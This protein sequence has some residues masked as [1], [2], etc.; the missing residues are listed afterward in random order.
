MVPRVA[1]DGQR[2][3]DPTVPRVG[4]VAGAWR[5]GLDVSGQV[6]EDTVWAADTVRVVGPLEVVNG[7]TLGIDAGVR[8]EF[9]GFHDLTVEGRVLAMGTA[10][11]PVVFTSSDPAAFLP[12]SSSVGAWGGI[13]FDWSSSGNERS[14]FEH[15]VFECAKG[16]GSECVGG[17]LTV[18]GF[19]K[20]LVRNSLF[21]SNA[22]VYGGA[23][24]CTQQAAPEFVGCLF[25]G[26][27]AFETGS[28]FYSEYS[29]PRL[30]ACTLADN[31]VLN[32]EPF[33]P[34]GVVHNHIAKTSVAS[35]IVRENESSYF[36]DTQM[37]EAKP[38]YVTYSNVEDLSEGIGNIDADALFVGHGASPYAILPGSPCEDAGEPDT[39]GM[40]LASCDLAGEPRVTGGRLD[41]GAYE[42][43]GATG[44]DGGS[45]RPALA[46]ACLGNPATGR[47][48]VALTS[49]AAAYVRVDVFD[50]AGRHVSTMASGRVPAGSTEIVWDGRSDN[51]R[52][53]ANGVY[54]IRAESDSGERAMAKVVLLR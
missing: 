6:L 16:L 23:V 3:P 42:G 37:V 50:A 36:I 7:V 13:R 17:A 10:T 39:L 12:D 18:T 5:A 20:L 31:T 8:V 32:A 45:A 44:V 25:E 34:A 22:A 4:H 21:R 9:Q 48:V 46:L 43:A 11:E 49:P 1:H 51:G 40:G 19:S 33:D 24:G 27:S 28:A 54:F 14:V 26:N 2:R 29:Y 53:A 41:M 35:S 30:V 47:P 38:Y 15:C 52:G